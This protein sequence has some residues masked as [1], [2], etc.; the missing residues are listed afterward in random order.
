VQL[1]KD[2]S[3]AEV[4][5]AFKGASKFASGT[6][7]QVSIVGEHKDNVV[8]IPSEAI[9]REGSEAY[10]M[11]VKAD[12]KAHKQVVEVG[13][14]AGEDVEIIRGVAAGDQ[15]IV[16]GQHELPDGAAVTLAKPE[17]PEKS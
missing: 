7:L 8:L 15:V 17:K 9:V 11:I 6:P 1:D 3:V 14:S 4:R 5:L 12:K 13:L 16:D 2:G 10:V